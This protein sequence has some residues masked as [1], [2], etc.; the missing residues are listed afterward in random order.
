MVEIKGEIQEKIM[1]KINEIARDNVHGATYLTVRALDVLEYAMRNLNGIEEDER[2]N[3][4]EDLSNELTA[5]QPRMASIINLSNGIKYTLKRSDPGEIKNSLMSF[6]KDYRNVII[7]SNERIPELAAS[8]IE[9]GFTIF[10]H[11]SSSLVE[12]SIL[13]AGEKFDDLSVICT[14]SRPAYE[15]VYLAK[16]LSNKGINTH[17]VIDSGI[18]R[19]LEDAD[20]VMVGADHISENGLENKIGTLGISSYCKNH[21]IPVYSVCQTSKIIEEDMLAVE[22]KKDP[23]EVW[24]E[25]LENVDVLN[26][27]FD[28]SPLGNFTG[29]VTERGIL[30][31]GE[32]LSLVR[33]KPGTF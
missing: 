16:T 5:S 10:T 20:I 29:I 11:S 28:T 26:Y 31:R 1:E 23:S 19:F 24:D 13:K 15:G 6:L 33:S 9:K 7:R 22:M 8:L 14:E 4:L 17:I 21:G 2:I 18:Y 32:I 25:K 30:N 12:K 3:F 27:Y